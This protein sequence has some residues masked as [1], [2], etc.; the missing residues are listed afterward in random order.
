[1]Y[2]R[3]KRLLFRV[4]RVDHFLR[5]FE[6]RGKLRLDLVL[7]LHSGGFELGFVD[8]DEKLRVFAS[9]NIGYKEAVKNGTHSFIFDNAH[10]A[11]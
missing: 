11:R 3:F 7:E 9:V 6:Q 5:S 4:Q 2:P 1:M 8:E 10:Q